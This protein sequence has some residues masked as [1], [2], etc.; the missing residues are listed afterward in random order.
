MQNKMSMKHPRKLSLN[1]IHGLLLFHSQT[2]KTH[3]DLMT[4]MLPYSLSY[5]WHYAIYTTRHT[6]THTVCVCLIFLSKVPM[7]VSLSQTNSHILTKSLMHSL[8]FSVKVALLHN[9][10]L[11]C[12]LYYF[13]F[14]YEVPMDIK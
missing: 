1:Y 10:T 4:L 14:L 11:I 5:C 7:K 3:D 12:T 13:P 8:F 9:Q 2:H 6:H